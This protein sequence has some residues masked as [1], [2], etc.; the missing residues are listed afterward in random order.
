MALDFSNPIT[1]ILSVLSVSF[2]GIFLAGAFFKDRLFCVFCPMLAL[3]SVLDRI[4]FVRFEKRADSCLG[5][6]NCQRTCP[7]DIRSLREM[8]ADSSALRPECLQCFKCAE[9]C[10]QDGTLTVKLLGWRLF[11]SSKKHARKLI[12]ERNA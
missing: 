8:K 5:C 12:G 10:P 4:G 3:L 7:A 1:L 11:S 2:A 9:A 6:G